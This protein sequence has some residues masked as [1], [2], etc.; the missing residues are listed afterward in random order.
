MGFPGHSISELPVSLVRCAWRGPEGGQTLAPGITADWHSQLPSDEAAAS[1]HG[2][3]TDVR[4]ED[5]GRVGIQGGEGPHGSA[6]DWLQG[7]RRARGELGRPWTQ[8]RLRLGGSGG[9][10]EGVLSSAQGGSAGGR[11][12]EHPGPD[13]LGEDLK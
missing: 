8:R 10:W 2:H 6:V 11:C 3:S 5:A 13:A 4:A 9:G 1:V 12:R 7:Q